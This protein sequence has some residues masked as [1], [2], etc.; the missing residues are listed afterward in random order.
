MEGR[1]YTH[2]K[3]AMSQENYKALLAPITSK[4]FVINVSVSVDSIEVM[5]FAGD[6]GSW[7]IDTSIEQY[8]NNNSVP[9]H[10]ITKYSQFKLNTLYHQQQRAENIMKKSNKTRLTSG[11]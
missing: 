10:E 8:E 9:T 7:Y 3:D 5:R 6:R 2:I 1:H 4:T 11:V